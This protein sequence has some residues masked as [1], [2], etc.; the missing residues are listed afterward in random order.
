MHKRARAHVRAA[1]K[2]MH[3][4]KRKAIAHFGRAMHYFGVGGPVSE[5]KGASKEAPVFGFMVDFKPKQSK[6]SVV[7]FHREVLVLASDKAN[8][9]AS[10]HRMWRVDQPFVKQLTDFFRKPNHTEW[11]EFDE[12]NSGRI[13]QTLFITEK[14]EDSEMLLIRSKKMGL[15]VLMAVSL[16]VE[17]R[18][19]YD[20]LCNPKTTSFKLLNRTLTDGAES[21]IDSVEFRKEAIV[22]RSP[23]VFLITALIVHSEAS[24]LEQLT[25]IEARIHTSKTPF[26]DAITTLYEYKPQVDRQAVTAMNHV[27]IF[28]TECEMKPNQTILSCWLTTVVLSD[29][30]TSDELDVFEERIKADLASGMA[31]RELNAKYIMMVLRKVV[32]EERA[33]VECVANRKFRSTD[34]SLPSS[35]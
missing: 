33:N 20:F 1:E 13:V 26:T 27:D 5:K 14:V 2:Y 8:V 7:Y 29:H 35:L 4:D 28:K 25:K 3:D 12:D 30:I 18:G 22:G 32:T 34:L 21:V 11:C 9:A 23:P 15:L 31:E 10:I 6:Q 24:A 17:D 19:L 16:P